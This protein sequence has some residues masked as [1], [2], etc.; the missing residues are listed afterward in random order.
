MDQ[1]KI[2]YFQGVIYEL[3]KGI[4][5]CSLLLVLIHFF[6]ATVHVV[7]GISMEPNFSSNQIVITNR[8]SYMLNDPQRGDVVMIKFP[9]DPDKQK[10]VK[11]IVG[12]PGEKIEIKDC[13]IYINSKILLESYIPSETCTEPDL[14]SN[15]AN[16][17]YFIMGDN[18]P[19]S[20]DSRAWGTARKSDLI[21]KGF[22]RLTPFDKFGF[23]AP[24]Y[25]EK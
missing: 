3:G 16:D 4:I 17:E 22:F 23:L 2:L 11:R 15:I 10:Y 19:N 8:I 14:V 20:N 6:V 21:G 24:V 25:Y 13:K 9:G 5:I 18:R 7:S 1:K 12:L